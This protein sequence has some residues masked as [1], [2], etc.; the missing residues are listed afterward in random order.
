MKNTAFKIGLFSILTICGIYILGG[1][2][3]DSV[4]ASGWFVFVFLPFIEGKRK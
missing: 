4:M 3:L 1:R 2:F